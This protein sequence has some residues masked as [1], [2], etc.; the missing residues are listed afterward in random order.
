MKKQNNRFKLLFNIIL[1][2]TIV[3]STSI[4]IA[5]DIPSKGSSLFT[6]IENAKEYIINNQ[7][8]DGG[9]PLIPGEESDVEVTALAIW[10]LIDA[11]WGTGSSIVRRGV[12]F[13]ERNQHENGSWNNNTAHT[14]F[15]V[16]AL[17]KGN[18]APDVRFKALHWHKKAQNR[19]GSWGSQSNNTGHILYTAASLVGLKKLGLTTR[20][21]KPLLSG[22]EWIADPERINFDGGWTLPSGTQSDIY[23]TSWVLQALSP[24][25]DLDEQIAW[26]KQFQN[27]DGGFGRYRGNAS[28]PEVTASVIM[29]LAASEDPLN[30]RRIAI[31]Y[32][33][34][35]QS[36]NGGFI[37]DTPI[38]LKT[39][40][41]NLQTTCFVL[42][43]I[44][45][46]TN[47]TK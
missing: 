10:S 36:E 33:T 43:A 5:Q 16:I 6:T 40:T 38:E 14:I 31:S 30:T 42:I 13:L 1:L 34:K 26:I 24:D 22:M 11:D 28:D 47:D 41:E 29:A 23:V 17:A 4:T 20:H 3:L 15:S 18:T 9:W 2:N 7:N 19:S 46:N 37:S 27:K 39:P 35:A 25:Y 12:R 32:F 45:A 44:H 21:F 8:V